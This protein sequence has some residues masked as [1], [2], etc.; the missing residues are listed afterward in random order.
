MKRKEERIL[1]FFEFCALLT[2]HLCMYIYPLSAIFIYFSPPC[3]SHGLDPLL[4]G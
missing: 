1:V 2:F 3:S 4:P